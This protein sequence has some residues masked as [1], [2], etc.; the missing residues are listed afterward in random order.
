[1]RFCHLVFLISP[2]GLILC[3]QVAQATN[4]IESFGSDGNQFSMEFVHI[5]NPGNV[6]D[7][8]G[9][10]SPAGKVDYGYLLG[11]H[12]VSEDMIEK[13]NALGNLGL[14][15]IDS[16]G[17]NKP[18]TTV[19]WNEAARFVNW[20]NTSQ[21]FQAAYNF[22]TNPGDVRYDA[23]QNIKL[24][25]SADAWQQGG[26]NLFRHKNAH[27]FLPS[28]DEWYKAAY[29]NPADSSYFDFPTGSDMAPTG[30]A[31]GTSIDTAVYDQLFG[32][33]PADITQ[34]G[35]LSPYGTMGQGGNVFEWEE[36]SL[37]RSNSTS[38]SSRRVRG[39]YWLS[40][41][42]FDLSTSGRLFFDPTFGDDIIGFRV[43]SIPEP[44]AVTHG[45]VVMLGLSCWRKFGS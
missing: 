32:T 5:G 9:N 30:V 18:A 28:A 34:A 17:A 41:S 42:S 12:E 6:N 37:D 24:W 40:I 44:S 3:H 2:I 22:P 7:T 10:P 43:A 11:K 19:T 15:K 14:T 26:E 31:S 23:N 13:A 33:G 25:S 35:G 20:L 16:R 29:Y 27:Y 38:S 8:S 39:G 45:C 1:M 36:S 21:G 4:L